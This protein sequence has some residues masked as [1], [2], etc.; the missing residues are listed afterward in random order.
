MGNGEIA[1][2]EQ[3]LLFPHCFQKTCNNKGLFGKGLI[4]K[5]NRHQNNDK[6][7]Q[8]NDFCRNCCHNKNLLK[9]SG[10]PRT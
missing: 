3:F 6:Q 9:E 4:V 2:Y 8:R 1:C 10:Q 5:H 7:L